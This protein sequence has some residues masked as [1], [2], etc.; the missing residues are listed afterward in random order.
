MSYSDLARAWVRKELVDLTQEPP[1]RTFEIYFRA[2][3]VCANG[4]GD[5]KDHERQWVLGLCAAFGGNDALL[6]TLRSYPADEGIKEVIAGHPT[7]QK[8]GRRS[9]L[10]N[11]IEACAADGEYAEGE[12]AR[13]RKMAHAMNV[14][15]EEVEQLEALYLEQRALREKK[16]QLLH[17]DGVLF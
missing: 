14:P 12:R 7:V 2:L 16:A 11:A 10:F 8:A 6:D 13:V 17:P 15:L 9:L 3:L 5:L 4:D 1:S